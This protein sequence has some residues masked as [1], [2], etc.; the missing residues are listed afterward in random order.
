MFESQTFYSD[1][2][3]VGTMA[4]AI[5]IVPFIQNSDHSTIGFEKVQFSKRDFIKRL[6]IVVAA[7]STPGCRGRQRWGGPCL[8][9]R[10]NCDVL[11]WTESELRV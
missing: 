1:F 8:L 7:A 11:I 2:Q 5:T 6:K 3:M 4:I 10:R 9:R